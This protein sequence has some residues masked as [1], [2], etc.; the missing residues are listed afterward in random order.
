MGSNLLGYEYCECPMGDHNIWE[1]P[2]YR[3]IVKDRIKDVDTQYKKFIIKVINS[4]PSFRDITDNQKN[5]FD[6]IFDDSNLKLPKKMAIMDFG[7]GKLKACIH[8]LDKTNHSVYPIEFEELKSKKTVASIEMYKFAERYRK[9]LK[10]IKFPHNFFKMRDKVSLVMAINVHNVMPIPAERLLSILYARECLVNNGYYLYYGQCNDNAVLEKCKPEN[11]ISD[12]YFMGKSKKYKTFYHNYNK[13]ED[14]D[15]MFYMN[16]FNRVMKKSVPI[17]HVLLYKKVGI[18]P[19]SSFFNAKFI[20]KYVDGGYVVKQ[21]EDFTSGNNVGFEPIK[22]LTQSNK[23]TNFIPSQLD[24]KVL[25]IKALTKLKTGTDFASPYKYLISSIFLK[26]F[27]P[28]L[29]KLQTEFVVN[30]AGDTIDI[31]LKNHADRGFFN[32]RDSRMV[33]IECKNHKFDSEKAFSQLISRFNA[34]R[35]KF[36]IIC[37]RKDSTSN[38]KENLLERCKNA[39]RDGNEILCLNDDDIIALLKCAD[40]QSINDYLN[41]KIDE[42]C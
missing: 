28:Y 6:E 3:C 29:V 4:A 16:G 17:N 31:T 11:K 39:L 41:D 13:P 35:G 18:N 30:K 5:V 21:K 25:M 26:L 40:E 2:N 14:I 19:L 1:T 38:K 24:D 15:I 36:G 7:A 33:M 12:G 23:L 37:Y 20:R 32:K 22:E 10:E 27:S 42:L 9:R 34:A 8:I